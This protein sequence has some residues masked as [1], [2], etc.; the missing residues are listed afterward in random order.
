MSEA[1]LIDLCAREV[2]YTNPEFKNGMACCI[3]RFIFTSA[4]IVDMD[5]AGYHHRYCY[6]NITDARIA[7]KEWNGT[8]DPENY[9]K[10]K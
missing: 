5:V 10:R 7:F 4:I 3:G 6:H 2:G 8:G 9:I 1:E